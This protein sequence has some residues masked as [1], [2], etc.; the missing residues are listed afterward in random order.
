MSVPS[1]QDIQRIL[2]QTDWIKF[3]Q[4]AS[5]YLRKPVCPLHDGNT[6]CQYW[7]S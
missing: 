7:Q 4:I 6:L 2:A 1:E 5:Y 3:N